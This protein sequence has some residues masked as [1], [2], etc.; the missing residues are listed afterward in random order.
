MIF[1][2]F[3]SVCIFPKNDQILRGDICRIKIE[4]PRSNERHFATSVMVLNLKTK[5]YLLC[6][7]KMRNFVLF[8]N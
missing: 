2:I 7:Q 4:N 6:K 3:Y 1:I 8:L 5:K